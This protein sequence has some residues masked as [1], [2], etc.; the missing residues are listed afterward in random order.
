M[1]MA[2]KPAEKAG[3][4]PSL[5]QLRARSHLHVSLRERTRSGIDQRL[6]WMRLLTRQSLF[7]CG[8]I[9]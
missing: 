2:E 4:E 1:A 9:L 6:A 8:L 3:A 5:P 7:I